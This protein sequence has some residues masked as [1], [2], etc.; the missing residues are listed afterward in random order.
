MFDNIQGSPTKARSQGIIVRFL[1]GEYMWINHEKMS[2]RIISL[3]MIRSAM[4][5][6]LRSRLQLSKMDLNLRSKISIKIYL[7]DKLVHK[8]LSMMLDRSYSTSG[9]GITSGTARG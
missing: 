6:K 4:M 1:G 3:C 2:A 7:E 8:V 5:K 9:V